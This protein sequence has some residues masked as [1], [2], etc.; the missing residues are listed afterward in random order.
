MIYR[1]DRF[2][3]F[4]FKSISGIWCLVHIQNAKILGIETVF[5]ALIN[6]ARNFVLVVLGW[7][8]GFFFCEFLVWLFV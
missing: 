1:T 6:V 7:Q 3:N 8:R 4:Y 2:E 5:I